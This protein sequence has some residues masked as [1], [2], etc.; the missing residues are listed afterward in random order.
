M[1][2]TEENE[3][4]SMTG[5]ESPNRIA[6]G[7]A[8]KGACNVQDWTGIVASSAGD[9][10]TAGLRADGSVVITGLNDTRNSTSGTGR[11]S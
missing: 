9:F 2:Q 3:R 1:V 5:R 10:F 7:Q 4:V 6:A 11:R 8:S